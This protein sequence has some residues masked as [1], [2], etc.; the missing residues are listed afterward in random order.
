MI[1]DLNTAVNEMNQDLG[2]ISKWA[3]DWRMS[4]NPGPQ[5]ETVEFAFSKRKAEANHLEILFN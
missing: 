3:R 5:K 1:Q 4:F 2:L